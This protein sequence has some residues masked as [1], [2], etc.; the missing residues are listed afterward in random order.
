VGD[1]AGELFET[2]VLTLQFAL[3]GLPFV[4]SLG[5]VEGGGGVRGEQFGVVHV[6]IVQSL[7]ADRHNAPVF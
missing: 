5:P 7:A 4:L 2:L 1:D 3:I 6:E